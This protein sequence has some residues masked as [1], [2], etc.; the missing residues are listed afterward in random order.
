M[1]IKTR[2]AKPRYCKSSH[3]SSSATT[4]SPPPSPIPDYSSNDEDNTGRMSIDKLRQSDGDGGESNVG[5][6]SSD[7]DWLE[8]KSCLMCNMGGQLLLCSEIGCPIA[9]HKECIVSK[10][11]YDE[12]GNFYCPYCWFKLQLSITGKLKKKVLLTKKVLE[13][14]LGHNLTEVGGNKENQND[15]RAKGKDSN[16]IAVMGENRCCDNKRMEQETNDQQVD[17]EQDEGEGVLEDEE[18]MESLN[19]MGEN[20]CRVNKR[21]EQDT[22]AQ[23]VDKKQENGEGVFEDEEET[24]LLNVM[25][26]NHCHDSLKMM[27]Q[28]TN[29]QKVDNK[30]DEGVF[31]DEDQT[32]SLTVQCVEKETTFDGVLLHESAGANSKTMK[33]PKEKQAMEEEKEK[34]HEDAPEINVSYTSKEAALDDAGTFD[35]DTET[36]AVRKRSVKKAKIKYAVSPKKPSSHAYTTSAEETRNQNDKVGFFGRSCKKPTTHPAAEARNQNKKVNLLD[37]SRPTQVSAKKLTKMPFSHEKRKRLLWRPEEEEMLREGVQ[38]F[39][40]KVNKNLP[41]RKILEFGRHVFDA[42][43]SP[44]DLKDKWRNLLAKESS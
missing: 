40:S 35:S 36:L 33:S 5:E 7:N 41:W 29:N 44:S 26:E 34:I 16:I 14:F 20:R 31:E 2:S 8:E 38:K 27:E 4:T 24:K 17:K 25:G 22:N 10:P 12:E 3:R 11:R 30:Q 9:L 21:M 32:E 43:R 19:V 39:S 1:R 6:D 42:S 28:E 15:G 37:R 23:Q 18:Q 13:S